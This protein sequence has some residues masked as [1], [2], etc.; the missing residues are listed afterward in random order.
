MT[1]IGTHPPRVNLTVH[2]GEPVDF[3]VPA[4]NGD[5]GL[6][7]AT[8]AGWTAAAQIRVNQQPGAQLLHNLTVAIEGVTVRVTATSAQTLTWT[9][10]GKTSAPWDLILIDT[11]DTPH[12]LCAG[13]VRVYPTT[14]QI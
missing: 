4:L 6:P 5:T 2:A 14:T 3:T 8:L 7:V 10:W 11:T 12:V 9:A 13:R 1:V